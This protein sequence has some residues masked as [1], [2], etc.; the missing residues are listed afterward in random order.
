MERERDLTTNRYRQGAVAD[1]QPVF[2][3]IRLRRQ[4]LEERRTSGLLQGNSDPADWNWSLRK[5]LIAGLN[6]SY[7]LSQVASPS[8]RDAVNFSYIISLSL[9]FIHGVFASFSSSF[10]RKRK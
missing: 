6:W 9:T 7:E 10:P 2:E 3:C 8:D 1:D 4:N 5:Y